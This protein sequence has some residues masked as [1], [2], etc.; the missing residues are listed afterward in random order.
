MVSE[1]SRL[2]ALGR[3][4]GFRAKG[5][6]LSVGASASGSANLAPNPSSPPHPPQ[7]AEMKRTA[8][9]IVAGRA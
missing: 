4:W 7:S 6:G 8:F 2:Q 9:S 3:L 1:G 5:G